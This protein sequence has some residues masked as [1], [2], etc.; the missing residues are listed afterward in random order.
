M[1]AYLYWSGRDRLSAAGDDNLAIAHNGAGPVA[2]TADVALRARSDGGYNWFTYVT[3]C[4]TTSGIGQF[5][6]QRVH[7]GRP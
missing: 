7:R 2:V 4:T 5:R 6:A 3:I 1:A